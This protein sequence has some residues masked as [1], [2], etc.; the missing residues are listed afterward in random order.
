MTDPL[1][2]VTLRHVRAVLRP[3][4]RPLCLPGIDAWCARHGIDPAALAG[5]G[6]P[7]AQVQA[8]GDRYALKAL[9]VAVEEARRGQ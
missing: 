8:I 2:A 3:G 6:V 9:A 4:R 1:P 7:G 5:P